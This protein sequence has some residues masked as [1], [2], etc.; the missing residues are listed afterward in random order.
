MGNSLLGYGNSTNNSLTVEQV[1]LFP[2]ECKQVALKGQQRPV[3]NTM[4]MDTAVDRSKDNRTR[5]YGN[6]SYRNNLDYSSPN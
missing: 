5:N 2:S 4:D 3:D 1:L 6:Q